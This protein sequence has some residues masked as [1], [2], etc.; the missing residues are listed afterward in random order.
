MT[1]TKHSG[2]AL[3]V[4]KHAKQLAKNTA[5]Y[6]TTGYLKRTFSRAK[7]NTGEYKQTSHGVKICSMGKGESSEGR[8]FND[9]HTHLRVGKLYSGLICLLQ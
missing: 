7:K 9:F 6:Y 1:Q 5:L 3:M 8:T 4:Y 2:L